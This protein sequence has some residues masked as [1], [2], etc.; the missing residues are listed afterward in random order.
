MLVKQKNIHVVTIT[1]AIFETGFKKAREDFHSGNKLMYRKSFARY[2]ILKWNY[3]K[4]IR[5]KFV[6]GKG[7]KKE[8]DKLRFPHWEVV[9]VNSSKVVKLLSR[10]QIKVCLHVT[11]KISS[12]IQQSSKL[13]TFLILVNIFV[14]YNV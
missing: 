1:I 5:Y 12:I 4:K 6:S 2:R 11:K 7:L 9:H 8:E 10:T 13:L 3:T 14:Y